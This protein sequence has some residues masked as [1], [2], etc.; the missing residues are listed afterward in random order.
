MKP[1]TH[2]SAEDIFDTVTIRTKHV[3]NIEDLKARVSHMEQI[4]QGN[5][6]R[7][8]GILRGTKGYIN[9]EYSSGDIRITNCATEGDM[10]CIIG[11]NL[12]RQKLC[13]LFNGK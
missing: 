7:A 8:K 11:R 1:H 12:N 10:L 13:S 4:A 3:F 6:I 5:V 2:H 9:L